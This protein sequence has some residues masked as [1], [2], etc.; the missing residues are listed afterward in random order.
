MALKKYNPGFLSNDEIVASFCVRSAE[1][2]S[3]LEPLYEPGSNS[4]GH[5]LVVGPRGSGKTHL[6]RRVAAE[7]RRDPDLAG[8][9]PVVF[10]EESYEVT[11]CGE[12]WLEC[13][14]HLAEQAPDE[15]RDGLL[16]SLAEIRALADDYALTERCLGSLLDFSDRQGR[17][18]LLLVENLNMLF[19][20]MIDDDAGWRLRKTLQAEPR[21]VLLGSATSRF[22]EIDDPDHAMFDL[23]RIITLQP[24]NTDECGRLWQTIADGTPA[25]ETIRPLQILTDGNVRLL[26]ILAQFGKAQSFGNLMESLLDLVDDHTDYFKSHL[27]S[28]PPLERRVYLALA[29]LW[30]PATAREVAEQARIDSNRTSALLARLVRRGVV[31]LA[32]GTSRRRQYY[33]TE[34]LYNMYYLLRRGGGSDRMVEALIDFMTAF[35]APSDFAR[36]MEDSLSVAGGHDSVGRQWADQLSAGL[37]ERMQSNSASHAAAQ[38]LAALKELLQP[39]ATFGSPSVDAES[40]LEMLGTSMQSAGSEHNISLERLEQLLDRYLERHS[41]PDDRGKPVEVLVL[42]LMM[43][44]QQHLSGDDQAADAAFQRAVDDAHASQLDNLARLASVLRSAGSSRA[45]RVDHALELAEAA[46]A[47]NGD[48]EPREL[49]P[50]LLLAMDLKDSL[51]KLDLQPLA[52][53]D[54]SLLLRYIVADGRMTTVAFRIL[55]RFAALSDPRSTLEVIAAEHA[56]DIVW[57]LVVALQ[58]EA[59]D[60]PRVAQEVDEVA[61]DVGRLLQQIRAEHQHGAQ[62]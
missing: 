62:P 39:E 41:E 31:T 15:E 52:A 14:T 2:E 55:V 21:I 51:L 37:M 23:F 28:L 30:K 34:R 18:L 54:I 56:S 35:Y 1:L 33:L 38:I 59:G 12:F 10:A 36:L 22:D 53:D 11:T 42:E 19:T 5:S 61:A 50:A 48:S 57:P 4:S 43:A 9:F 3:L 49:S 32:G 13:L 29:R 16:N 27:E 7:V 44:C 8:L 46:I 25:Q 20:D 26:A 47:G 6:L 40:L 58:R 60:R 24:L 45:G 17:R